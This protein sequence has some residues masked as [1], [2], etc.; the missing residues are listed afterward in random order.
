MRT[1]AADVATVL[2]VLW[3]GAM[4]AI[5]Y[6]VAPVLFASLPDR[7]LA[8][9]V[10]G[11]LFHLLGW[12]GLAIGGYLLIFLGVAHRCRGAARRVAVLVSL[13]LLMAAAQHFALQPRMAALKL[14]AGGDVLSGVQRDSFDRLHA[15]SGVLYLMQS[16]GGVVLVLLW[17]RLPAS[18]LR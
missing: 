18:Q 7:M 17:R 14:E 4:W 2:I 16:L 11:R 12:G 1:V 3:V 8:G 5:G 15:V 6:L 13:L 9:E 10:A